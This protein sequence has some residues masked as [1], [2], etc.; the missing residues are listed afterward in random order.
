MK[1]SRS[2][3]QGSA[4]KTTEST[5]TRRRDQVQKV[6]GYLC[7]PIASIAVCVTIAALYPQPA[8]AQPAYLEAFSAYY[9]NTTTDNAAC[10]VCHTA[11]GGG[12]SWNP[13]GTALRANGNT[14][15]AAVETL[16]SD[17]VA[18]NNFQEI[19]AGAQ[20]GWCDVANAG[21]VN[22]NAPPASVTL[23]AFAS[24]EPDIQV[25]PTA[26]LFGIVSPTA[27]KV[28]GISVL[29][30][31]QNTLSGTV[32]F[33]QL[34]GTPGSLSLVTQ[35]SFAILGG[36][37]EPITLSFNPNGAIGP[38]TG[39]LTIVSNDPDTPSRVINVSA[40]SQIPLATYGCAEGNEI[41]D[42]LPPLAKGPIS[43]RLQK[44][45][46]GFESP[47][48]AATAPGHPGRLFVADQKGKL[49]TV[50]IATGAKTVFLDVGSRL[51]PVGGANG[52]GYDERGLLGIAFHPKYATNGLLY[53][54]LSVPADANG[55]LIVDIPGDF[56]TMA[57]EN[58]DFALPNHQS[59]IMEWKVTNPLSAASI[60]NPASARELLRFDQPQS[61]HNGGNMIFD[62]EGRLYIA[63][64][65]GGGANDRVIGHTG[66]GTDTT[67]RGNGQ[68]RSNIMGDILRIDPLGRNSLNGKYG[69]PST[70]PFVANLNPRPPRLG[71]TNGCFDGFCDEIFASGIRNTW[72][73]SFD[74][75]RDGV[76]FTADVGQNKVEEINITKAG[77]N[78]GWPILEANYCFAVIPNATN[79]LASGTGYISDSP[80]TGT[81]VLTAPIATYDHQDGLSITG[82][83]VYRGAA[84]RALRGHYVFGDWAL[85]FTGYVTPQDPTDDQRRLGRLFYLATPELEGKPGEKSAILEFGSLGMA[86][87]IKVT[88]FGQD[89]AGE[90]YVLGNRKGAP[91]DSTGS[92]WKLLPA[93]AP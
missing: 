31:G 46:D 83:F 26:L 6:V 43:I 9:P 24:I 66:P 32:T 17:G 25:S 87:P 20:P 11:S 10:Q 56:S 91:S 35:G 74:K 64:G 65:D 69:V 70:N 55:D 45:A 93:L 59:V 36:T 41:V 34:T 40:N 58:P 67:P 12:A 19:L 73:M 14:N 7:I 92:I 53:T 72:G 23:D 82:G 37:A 1:S 44:L 18:G 90:L 68:S 5:F 30:A 76:L 47:T 52:L 50:N 89:A 33:T 29:N 2:S 63:S 54:Y 85:S 22:A 88:A 48:Q 77:L 62:K 8:Q 39:T 13:Y 78:Y 42:P 84:I 16:N 80:Y 49:Y 15:F 60:P 51:V 79:P 86:M 3:A 27:S 71:G 28:A 81:R 4:C 38:S 61:N 75:A 21:C 57:N